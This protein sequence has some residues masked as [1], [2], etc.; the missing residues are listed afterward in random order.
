MISASARESATP[1]DRF[2][3]PLNASLMAFHLKIPSAKVGLE[4]FVGRK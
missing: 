1:N 3:K 4:I 2:S